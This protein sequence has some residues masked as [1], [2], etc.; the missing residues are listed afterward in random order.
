MYRRP[1]AHRTGGQTT[2]D[3]RHP[4]GECRSEGT[5]GAIDELVLKLQRSWM[6]VRLLVGA[7][8]PDHYERRQEDAWPAYSP[9]SPSCPRWI[10][11]E[12]STMCKVRSR[13]RRR[14]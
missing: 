11:S 6:S 4:C 12:R 3:D 5:D 1:R 9:S 7:V 2:G 13:V 10:A 8:L 14:A